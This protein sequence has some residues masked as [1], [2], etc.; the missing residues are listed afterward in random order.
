MEEIDVLLH[1]LAGGTKFSSPDVRAA[2]AS[3]GPDSR[4]ELEGLYRRLCPLEAK[5]LTRLLLKTYE[6]LIFYT[7][8]I[9]RL[10]DPALPAA[11]RI[12]D[13]F[14]EAAQAVQSLKNRLLPNGSR[15]TTS[16]CKLFD[17]I[18]PRTG[19]KVGRQPWLKGRSIK[20]CIDMSH[21]RMSVEEKIDGEYA[22]IH[23][24]LAKPQS[25]IQIFSKSGK[26][27]TEDRKKVHR[28]VLLLYS[29]YF[30]A[31]MFVHVIS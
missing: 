9:F 13:N 4:V 27:S 11:L 6:P 5:W 10:C 12:L 22:Q 23:I 18:K 31:D 25:P 8:T 14:S 29:L 7:E 15:K 16:A 20:H 26:D 1:A 24:D 28:S 30:P 19:V 3:D 17:S 21:G 2:K